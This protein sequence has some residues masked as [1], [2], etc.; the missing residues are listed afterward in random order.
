MIRNYPGTSSRTATT[1]RIDLHAEHAARETNRAQYTTCAVMS[2]PL[3]PTPIEYNLHRVSGARRTPRRCFVLY[4]LLCLRDHTWSGY[5]PIHSVQRI[6][7]RSAVQLEPRHNGY[8][9]YCIFCVASASPAAHRREH[10]SWCVSDLGTL[11]T[12]L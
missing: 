12:L 1:W 4:Y 10:N 8:N 2:Q 5:T 11:H 9:T 3:N 6:Q 7:T